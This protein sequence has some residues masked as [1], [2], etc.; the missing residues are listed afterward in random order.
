MNRNLKFAM[1][2]ALAAMGMSSQAHAVYGTGNNGYSSTFV[3]VFEDRGINTAGSNSVLFDLGTLTSAGV[4][5][6]SVTL[7]STA[8]NTFVSSVT[9][10]SDLKWGMFTA[11][12]NGGKTN[13][14]II[15]SYDGSSVPAAGSLTGNNLANID[16]HL[17]SVLGAY[18]LTTA[19]NCTAG[20]GSTAVLTNDLASGIW[21]NDA[22]ASAGGAMTLGLGSS[23]DLY[24]LTSTG[25]GFAAANG[26]VDLGLTATLTSGGQ[27]TIAAAAPVPEADSY[28]MMLAGLGLVGFMVRR[29]KSV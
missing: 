28:A 27:L 29:R 24:K 5:A 21:G 16:L 22:G 12:G 4:S 11:Y 8:W 19:S 23:M 13:S 1:V 9:M 17:N 15:N 3:Y 7:N 14:Y 18:G 6:Q 2:A 25:T 26:P 20:C 10:P